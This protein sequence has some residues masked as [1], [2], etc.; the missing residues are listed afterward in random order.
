MKGLTITVDDEGHYK[1]SEFDGGLAA[2]QAEVGGWIEPIPTTENVTIYVNEEGKLLGLPVNRLAMD[3]WIRYDCYRCVPAGDWI[4]GSA[5]V[6]GGV[7]DEG[8]TL[9]LSDRDRRWVRRVAREA[10]TV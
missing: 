8:E 5:V 6:V 2:L 7:D 1:L 10:I 3:V 9:D 4:A